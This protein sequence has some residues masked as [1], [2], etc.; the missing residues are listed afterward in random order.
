MPFDNYLD[1][2]SKFCIHYF[3]DVK[4]FGVHL[5][6]SNFT[7]A[8][9]KEKLHYTDLR[10]DHIPFGNLI[11]KEE[12]ITELILDILKTQ[13]GHFDIPAI[14]SY[15]YH[16]KLGMK[17]KEINNHFSEENLTKG[18]SPF[19]ILCQHLER[20]SFRPKY[21][22]D[23]LNYDDD[24]I[25]ETIKLMNYTYSI[26]KEP[27]EKVSQAQLRA[28]IISNLGYSLNATDRSHL[29]KLRKKVTRCQ[30][31]VQSVSTLV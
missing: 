15:V 14:M 12:N 7:F 18:K 20:W 29:S 31:F 1:D 6:L 24:G 3:D 19:S 17:K 26:N 28:L 30:E 9:D 16:H 4:N 8:I 11:G 27:G 23:H 25:H 10:I 2:L 5:D 13:I 22:R 21:E